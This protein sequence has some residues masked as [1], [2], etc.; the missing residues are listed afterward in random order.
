MKAVRGGGLCQGQVPH[1]VIVILP[2]LKEYFEYRDKQYIIR[3]LVNRAF[4]CVS[5]IMA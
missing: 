5:K 3:K 4:I 1:T 2:Y